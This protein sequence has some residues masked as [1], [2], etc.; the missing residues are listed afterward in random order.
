MGIDVG[1]LERIAEIGRREDLFPGSSVL[2]LGD[3]KFYTSWSCGNNL[4]DLAYFQ[5]LFGLSR[6]ETID[7]VGNPS[8]RLDLQRSLPSELISQFDLVIDAGTLFWCFDVAAVLENCLSALKD[9]GAMI[10]VCALTGHFGR[11]YYNIHPKMFRDFY[12]QNG[13]EILSTEVRVHKQMSRLANLQKKLWEWRGRSVGSYL[14]ISKDALFLKYA[15][16][17]SM[18]FT[19]EVASEAPMLPNDALFLCAA[20]REKRLSFVRPVP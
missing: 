19:D 17:V 12:E 13:F 10:H 1:F 7:I 9:R 15:D 16:F 4:E 18:E 5:R 8:I 2:I 11:G 20:R 3:C 6:V 14:P